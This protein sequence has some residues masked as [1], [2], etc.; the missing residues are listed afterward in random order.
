MMSLEDFTAEVLEGNA[1]I[2]TEVEAK[3]VH[4]YLS[5]DIHT[6]YVTMK[7]LIIIEYCT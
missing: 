7:I 1:G 5:H 4:R 3:A 6:E 2:L